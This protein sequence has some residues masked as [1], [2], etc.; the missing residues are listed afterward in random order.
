MTKMVAGIFF[1]E[2]G[3]T[4]M[5]ADVIILPEGEPQ[6]RVDTGLVDQHGERIYRRIR[7]EKFGFVG[8]D[9]NNQ[10]R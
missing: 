5:T 3:E 4:S 10:R 8:R 7:R 2:W 1:D 6:D 9:G